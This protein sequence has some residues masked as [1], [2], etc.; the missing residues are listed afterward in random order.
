M[1]KNTKSKKSIRIL[2]NRLWKI[3]STYIRKRDNYICFTCNRK[4]T[5][6]T[7]EAGHYIHANA[8]TKFDERN[9]HCQCTHCN[10]FK[11]GNLTEYAIRLREKY[12]E[13][14]LEELH[15]KKYQI[16]I[17]KFSELEELIEIYKEKLKQLDE[18]SNV[19]RKI[20]N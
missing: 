16:K 10:R 11:H 5:K 14:I 17:F 6:A 13:N 7:S 19:N 4:L 15:K 12:G 20:A 18:E 3:V 9:I 8:M 2:K 1:K